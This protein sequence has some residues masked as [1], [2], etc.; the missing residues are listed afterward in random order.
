MLSRVSQAMTDSG[1][2]PR[3]IVHVGAHRAQEMDGYLALGPSLIV[4]VEADPVHLQRLH[5]VTAG[6]A[7]PTRQVVI[8]ALIADVDGRQ[9][10]FHRF[11]NRGQSSSLFRATQIL[12]D[13]WPDV[14]ET[15][16][17]LQLTSSRLDTVLQGAAIASDDVDV[18]ILDIQGA[19]LMALNGAGT[20]LDHLQFLEVELSQQEIYAGAPRANVAQAALLDLGFEAVTHVKWH[21]GVVFRRRAA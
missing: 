17:V 13:H 3:G 8:Q 1:Y 21:G 7:G 11:S 9:H 10:D 4:W 6:H 2:R 18:L 5:K 14:R 15:G 19:E 20:Y 12:N 16:E